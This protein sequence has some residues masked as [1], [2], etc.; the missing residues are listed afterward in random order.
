[1]TEL[2]APAGNMEALRAAVSNGCDAVYLGLEKFGARAYSDNFT[3]ESLAEAIDY[4]HLR[5]VKIYVTMNTIVFEDEIADMQEQLEQLNAIGVDGII[6]QDLAVFDYVAGNFVDMEVHCSTQMGIDDLEGTLLFKEMGADRVVMAREV[7]IA[8]V[9]QIR[10][11]A[12]IP[13]EVFVHGALCVSYSGNCLMS[14]LI[15]YRS[16]NRG[17]C[18]GSCRKPYELLDRE[19][20]LSFGT[21]YLLSM[22]DLNTIDHIEELKSIDSLKIEGRMKEPAYVANVV[23]R[24]REALDGDIRQTDKD[25]L[26]KTFN[27]TYTEGYMFGE[28]PGNITNIQRPNNFGYEIGKVKGSYKGMYEIALTKTLH[29]N[30]IIRIDHENEDVNLSV[31]RLYDKDG[32][33]INQADKT[34]YIKIKEKLSPGDV[35]YKTKDYLFY[36]ELEANLDKEFRRFPLDLKV[37]AYPGAALVID[38]E[39]FGLQYLY[40]SEEILEEAVNNPT[41]REQAVKHLSRLG[42]TVFTLGDVEF[43]SYNAFVPAKLLNSARRQ[44]VQGLYDAKLAK[45]KKRMKEDVPRESIAFPLQKPYLTAT[46]TT[47]EQY[48]ACKACGIKDVYFDNIIRRNQNVYEDREGELLL[49]GYGGIYRYRDTNPFVTD[50]SLNV[51]NAASCYDLYRLGAKR[52]TL[53]YELNRRQIQELIASY[54]E[55]N[56]GNPAL[57][58]IVYGRA[59]LLFTKY[60]PLKKMGQCGSCRKRSYEL[61]DEYG[62]FPVLN[63]EDCSTTILNGKVLNLLDEMPQIDGVEA[64]RLNFT[65]ESGAEVK[66]VIGLAQQKLAG[67]LDKSVFN[68][69][70]DTRGHFN[71]E[72]L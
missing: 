29:Q 4:A 71:K 68:Q 35:V 6:V 3:I 28:E 61:K 65:I 22:K 7:D 52:V 17:R 2:L 12:K 70:T 41:D 8:D 30:D 49:G 25:A 24:Y 34:C 59:P 46:V 69:K 9:K 23:K 62:E 54:E 45:W 37:Y 20:G 44:I 42:D 5:D 57:E 40:E 72:I 38:A 11:A 13:I 51:V 60:C 15:G 31:A 16:G 55:V 26:Q 50:Y 43:E 56:G 14:G 67:T 48:D 10:K 58:M 1:M 36:K 18:V 63:H 39:G 21:S 33:L 19:T 32:M 27:R 53:S 64:F 66:R 47:Q